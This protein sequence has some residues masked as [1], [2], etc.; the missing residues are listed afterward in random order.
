MNRCALLVG[1]AALALSAAPAS[2]QGI[3]VYDNAALL[4]QA[5]VWL[6]QAA[7][8]KAQFQMMEATWTALSGARDMRGVAAALGGPARTYMPESGMVLDLFSGSTG[9]LWGAA[10]WMQRAA[11]YADIGWKPE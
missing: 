8:M 2:A 7:D 4:K 10:G 1:A 3:P 5:A 9:T 6:K 11:R